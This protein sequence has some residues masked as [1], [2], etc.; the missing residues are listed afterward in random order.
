LG[1]SGRGDPLYLAGNL[2]SWTWGSSDGKQSWGQSMV[3]GFAAY[4]SH[5]DT[6]L[7]GFVFASDG[8]HDAELSAGDSSGGVFIFANNQGKLTRRN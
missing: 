8:V 1:R 6:S 3:D 5:S 2:K 4:N 7:L